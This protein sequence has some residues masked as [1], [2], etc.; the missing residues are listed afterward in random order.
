MRLLFVWP[1]TVRDCSVPPPGERVWDDHRLERRGGARCGPSARPRKEKSE[2]CCFAATRWTRDAPTA[3]VTTAR[4]QSRVR[5]GPAAFATVGRCVGAVLLLVAVA[6]QV[7]AGHP[8]LPQF[9]RQPQMHPD[10]QRE[11]SFRAGKQAVFANVAQ[12]DTVAL[13]FQLD[14]DLRIRSRL[15]RRHAVKSNTKAPARA[16]ARAAAPG[17]ADGEEPPVEVPV[18]RFCENDEYGRLVGNR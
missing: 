16:G 17:A 12:D 2:C 13:G 11:E 6:V 4:R 5:R 10:P 8:W 14:T 9:C 1:H 15:V 18:I 3:R 7:D